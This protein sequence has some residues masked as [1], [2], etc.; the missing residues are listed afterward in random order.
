[1]YSTTLKCGH[2]SRK[3]KKISGP[4]KTALGMVTKFHCGECSAKYNKIAIGKEVRWLR[5]A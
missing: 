2:Q 5:V 1:M 4:I 3:T